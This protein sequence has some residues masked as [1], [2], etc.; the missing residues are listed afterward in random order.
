M[1]HGDETITNISLQNGPVMWVNIP[2]T[3]HMGGISGL[4]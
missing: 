3:K 2:Y 1:L 4:S